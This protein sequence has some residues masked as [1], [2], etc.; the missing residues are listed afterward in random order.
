MYQKY[1]TNENDNIIEVCN[2]SGILSICMG[3]VFSICL[4]SDVFLLL[5]TILYE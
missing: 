5:F 2:I 4:M 3:D 1:I